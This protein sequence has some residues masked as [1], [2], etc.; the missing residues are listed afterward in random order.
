MDLD[1]TLKLEPEWRLQ[2]T[3]SMQ[4]KTEMSI[5]ITS[6]PACN[7]TPTVVGRTC[8]GLRTGV[9]FK[10]S[11]RHVARVSRERRTLVH[12]EVTLV[13]VAAAA[14][15]EDGGDDEKRFF[16]IVA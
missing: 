9:G 11:T 1:T 6:R 4:V 2:I 7:N 16:Q 13:E 10:T 5:A 3:T 8:S 12:G 14:S 15:A